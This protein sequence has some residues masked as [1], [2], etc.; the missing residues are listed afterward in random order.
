MSIHLFMP[1]TLFMSIHYSF[2]N[3]ILSLFVW[4]L[5]DHNHISRL[6]KNGLLPG[7]SLLPVNPGRF[8]GAGATEPSLGEAIAQ[9][10]SKEGKVTGTSMAH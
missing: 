2:F 6:E 4:F 5:L 1:P 7:W 8:P 3:L 9:S 10:A